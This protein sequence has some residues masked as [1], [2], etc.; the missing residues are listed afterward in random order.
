MKK[1]LKIIPETINKI[2]NS[3]TFFSIDMKLQNDKH[4]HHLIESFLMTPQTKQGSPQFERVT[5]RS[6]PNKQT[7]T[8]LNI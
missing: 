5:T 4:A 2:S 6:H 3:K 1:H 8:Y 7:N